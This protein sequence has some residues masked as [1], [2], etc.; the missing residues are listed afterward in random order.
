VASHA[1]L[2]AFLAGAAAA[3]VL[4]LAV[5]FAWLR[6]NG[7]RPPFEP[8]LADSMSHL[9]HHTHKLTLSVEA[10]NDALAEFYLHEVGE[11]AEQ[12]EHLF[13]EHDGIPIATLARELL[14]PQLAALDS[15]LEASRWDAAKSGIGSLIG[16]CNDCHAATGHA[17]IRVERTSANPFN[18]SFAAQAPRR[19]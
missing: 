9:Q 13:P 4:L 7:E 19:Q 2:R 3:S 11:V 5:G 15:A 17:F 16:A 6:A 1:Q 10:E 12:I 18:Q 14:D 8:E